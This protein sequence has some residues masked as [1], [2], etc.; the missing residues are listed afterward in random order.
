[1]C[2]WMIVVDG[3]PAVE[4]EQFWHMKHNKRN[5][6]NHFY[7]NEFNICLYEDTNNRE[8]E[9]MKMMYDHNWDIVLVKIDCENEMV[10][11]NN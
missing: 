11:F 10:A 6:R 4:C 1:M 8:Y 7:H 2:R 3:Y 5:Y 9:F